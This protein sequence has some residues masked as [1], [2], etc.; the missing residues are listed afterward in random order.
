MKLQVM[1]VK[2]EAGSSPP[3]ATN[4]TAEFIKSTVNTNSGVGVKYLF[5]SYQQQLEPTQHFTMSHEEARRLK[6]LLF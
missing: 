4:N 2:S 6:G 5:Q 3:H 1:H